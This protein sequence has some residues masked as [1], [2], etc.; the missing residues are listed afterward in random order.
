MIYSARN[1]HA[2]WVLRIFPIAE[3]ST[4]FFGLGLGLINGTQNIE[5]VHKLRSD[6]CIVIKM[7]VKNKKIFFSNLLHYLNIFQKKD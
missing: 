7:T 3:K 6:F 1:N 5:V 4:C 2:I